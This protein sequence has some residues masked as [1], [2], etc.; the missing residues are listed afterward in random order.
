MKILG[1]E[2]SCDETA[3]SVL[4]I[5]KGKIK[6]LSNIVSSQIKIHAKYGGVVPHLAAREHEKN[7]PIV[8][9]KS[10]KE[11]GVSI[12]EIDLIAV[13][14]GPGLSPAL[15]RGVNFAKELAE[16]NKK[17]IIGANH[18]KG[19][20][21]SNWFNDSGKIKFLL[22]NLIVSGGHT[23]LVLM[24]GYEDLK[25]IGETLDDAAGE[26]FDK[27]ARFLNLG[28]PGGPIIS[29]LAEKGNPNAF[30]FPRPMLTQKN[31][32]FSFSGLKTPV[33]YL[34]RDLKPKALNYKLKTDICASFQRA[35]IDVLI[36]KTLKA[37]EKYKVK[38]VALSGGVSA[39]K[40][41]REHL[42]KACDEKNLDCFIA[43]MEYTTDNAAMIALA[44]YYKY[45][46]I[47]GQ[48]QKFTPGRI[49]VDANLRVT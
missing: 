17:P 40:A 9:E 7:L 11:A 15:W 38:A 22:L 49:K 6:V 34:I 25:I 18:L 19:H 20:I 8:L 41:L 47:K 21:Y 46:K 39:N 48:K 5:R 14:V 1:I 16:K 42:K 31:F 26:A 3:A 33:L 2:T 24:R 13:T 44:G 37:A 10:L 12:K 32:N 4:D 27:V 43:P 23:L 29:K 30:K 35:V 45:E 36:S 28:Y